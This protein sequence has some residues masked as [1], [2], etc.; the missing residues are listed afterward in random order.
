MLFQ[1][2]VGSLGLFTIGNLWV[3]SLDNTD[4]NSLPHAA[5]IPRGGLNTHGLAWS[6]DDTGSITGLDEL[7]VVFG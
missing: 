5:N 7:G 6:Q 3:C 2:L 1:G 4:S